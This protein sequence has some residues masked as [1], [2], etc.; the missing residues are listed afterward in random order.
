MAGRSGSTPP[1]PPFHTRT[2]LVRPQAQQ[3]SSDAS[4]PDML[5]DLATY[6]TLE[7]AQRYYGFDAGKLGI[8]DEQASALGVCHPT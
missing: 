2:P 5:R 6:L 1:P 8:S 4:S 7:K 3:G